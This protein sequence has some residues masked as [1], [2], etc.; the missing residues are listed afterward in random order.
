MGSDQHRSEFRGAGIDPAKKGLD[1]AFEE[2]APRSGSNPVRYRATVLVVG[3]GPTGLLLAAE[4]WRRGL[5]CHLIDARPAPLHW[6]RATVIHPRSLEIFDALGLVGRFLDAGCRQRI[7]A[8]HASGERL[9]TLDLA[10]SGSRFGFNLGLSEEVTESILTDYLQAQGGRVH[11]ASRLIDLALSRKGV[12]AT[13][14]HD[15]SRHRVEACWVVGCDGLRSATRNLAGI[16][17]GGRDGTTPWAVFDAT[18]KDWPDTFEGNFAYFD[19]PPVILTALPGS[20]WRIYLRPGSPTTDLVAEAGS[21]IHRYVPAV[22]IVDVENPARFDCHT[23][24]AERFRSG[25]VLLAGD[26]AHVCS[27]VEGHGM[28]AGLQDVFNL[29]WKLALVCQGRADPI[30]LDSYEAERRPVAEMITRSGA[31][32]EALQ[33]IADPNERAR[34]DRSIAA[35]LA[36]PATRHHEVVAEAEMNIAYTESPIVVG[37]TNDVPAPGER[38]PGNINLTLPGGRRCGLHELVRGVGHTLF[39]LGRNG[40]GVPAL[41]TLR[42]WSGM[43]T[44]GPGLFEPIRAFDTAPGSTDGIGHLGTKAAALLGVRELTLLAVRPDG[45]IGMRADANL[46]DALDAYRNLIRTGFTASV[47]DGT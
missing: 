21:T 35:R 7:V 12:L 6:D 14:E 8:I 25:P 1:K 9:G 37:T 41:D 42:A 34:R 38:L 39:L 15:G 10:S 18:L 45:H 47:G 17:F 40:E 44:E 36:N 43:D 13:V 46:V 29:A 26:A 11:R 5:A 28:N 4:L 2:S 30:L 31:A 33:D 16:G 22:R 3:A 19:T 23:R 27:P 32:A 20:R 24:I